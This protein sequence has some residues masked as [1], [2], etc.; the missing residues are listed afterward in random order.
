MKG[1]YFQKVR[2]NWKY[3]A[4]VLGAPGAPIFYANGVRIDGAQNFSVSQWI[5]FLKKFQ[6]DNSVIHVRR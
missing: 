4:G 5:E 6:P 1:E 3:V 2:N